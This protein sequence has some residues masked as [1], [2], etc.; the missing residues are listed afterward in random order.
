MSTRYQGSGRAAIMPARPV[1]G[2]SVN[3]PGTSSTPGQPSVFSVVVATMVAQVA[4]IMG[5]AV[6]PVVAPQLAT[7]MGVSP[8]WIGYQVSLTYGSA[9]LAAPLLSA[10]IA[11]WGGCRATQVG[12]ALSALGL[13][14]ALT[15]SLWALAATSILFGTALAI[16]VPASAHLLFRFC[17]PQRRNLVFSLKQTGVPVGW[18]LMALAAPPITVAFGWRWAILLVLAVVLVTLAALEPRRAR[19]DDDR[20]PQAAARQ[21]ALAGLSLTWRHAGL[22][23]LA[24]ASFFLSFVQLCLGSFAVTMLVKEAGYSLVAA[25]VMLSLVNVSGVAGRVLWGWYADHTGSGMRVLVKVSG[26]TTLCCV[27]TSFIAAGTP[28]AYT[29]LVFMVFGA[30]A[31]GWNGVFMAEVARCS[32]RGQVS[33]ATSG[34]MVWNF[35]GILVGPSLFAATYGLVGSYALTF[36]AL[37]LIAA[38]GALLLAT[39]SAVRQNVAAH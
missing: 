32:P 19:W 39:G 28:G 22:R 26:L 8:V 34:A 37:A 12:L 13:A 1:S 23:R 25:G 10:S 9:M 30:T 20:N 24:A 38:S 15:S 21:S 5:V 3:L 7:E 14:A 36:G 29:A 11:R 17:P 27:L 35:A 31:V 2:A 16:L 33:V 4:S 6:F 18:T